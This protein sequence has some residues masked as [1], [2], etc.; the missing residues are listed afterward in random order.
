MINKFK[1]IFITNQLI[2]SGNLTY[3]KDL[4]FFKKLT[5][6][7]EYIFFHFINVNCI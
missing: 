2:M 5:R 7:T 6:S 1:C 4:I 3:I